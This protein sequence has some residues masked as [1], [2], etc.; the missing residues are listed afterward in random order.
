MKNKKAFY[1]CPGIDNR[2]ISYWNT[3]R[4]VLFGFVQFCL[5]LSGFESNIFILPVP[6]ND[7]LLSGLIPIRVPCKNQVPFT[8]LQNM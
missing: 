5:F 7:A 4:R 3:F 2:I 1:K 8:R 6:V